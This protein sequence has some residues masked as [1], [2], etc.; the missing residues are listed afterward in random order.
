MEGLWAELLPLYINHKGTKTQ[1]E[2]LAT[3]L[4]EVFLNVELVKISQAKSK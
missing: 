1:R 2:A 4:A 3:S